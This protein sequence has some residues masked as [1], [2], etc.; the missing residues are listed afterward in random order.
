MVF[1]LAMVQR[2]KSAS[3]FRYGMVLLF[4]SLVSGVWAYTPRFRHFGIKD[5]LS[6]SSVTAL[7]QDKEGKIW[8]GTHDGLNCFYGT[9]FKRFY[10]DR[11]SKEGLNQSAISDL[12]CSADGDLWIATYGGGLSRM[13]PV[14]QQYKPLPKAFESFNWKLSNC[15]KEDP[16]GRLWFGFYEGLAVYNPA[17]GSLQKFSSLPGQGKK[18][19]SVISIGFDRSGSAIITTPFDGLAVFAIS[20]ESNQ[21]AFRE[22][23][24]QAQFSLQQKGIA[25]FNKIFNYRDQLFICSQEGI[26]VATF[27]GEKL[28]LKKEQ[29]LPE[30]ETTA[31]ETDAEGNFWIGN[32]AEGLSYY[33]KSSKGFEEQP[34]KFNDQP[35][36]KVSVL[37]KDNRGGMWVGH[38]SGL[39]YSHQQLAKFKS[40]TLF[41]LGTRSKLAITW[42]VFSE[43]DHHFLVGTELGLLF[44]DAET[45]QIKEISFAKEV[46]NEIIYSFLKTKDG[47]LFAGGSKGLYQILG[48]PSDPRIQKVLPQVVGMISALAQ[49]PDGRILAGT[50][51][52]RGFYLFSPSAASF[53]NFRHSKNN[54]NSLCNN[55]INCFAPE[56]S[57]KIW[58]GTD[59]GL[60]LFDPEKFRFDNSLWER[61]PHP[62]KNSQLIYGVADMG[63]ELWIAT[64]GSGILIYTKATGTWKQLGL[65]E[66]LSNEAVYQIQPHGELM[67]ASTN[68]GLCQIHLKTKKIA[69]FSE[70]DGL[71]SDEFNHFASFKNPTS[72]RIYFGG[73][74]GFDEVS[75]FLESRN[76]NSP[77]VVFSS[78]RLLSDRPNADLPIGAALWK[79]KPGERN[80]EVEFAALNYLM[81][82]KNTYAYEIEPGSGQI[83]LGSKSKLSLVNLQP[84]RYKLKIY[85]RNNEGLWSR[86]PLV[87]E[88]EVM[89]Y[90]WETFWFR[91]IIIFL[92]LLGLVLILT[93][94]YK[95]RLKQQRLE[96]ERLQAIRTERTRISAEMHDDLGSG[97]TSIRMMSELLQLKGLNKQVPEV[98]KISRRA[99]QLVDNLNTI[100][101]A[102]NE[103][104]DH[105]DAT[106]AYI[107][108]YSL[109]YLEENG[110]N[111]RFESIL[112]EAA[113]RKEI[114]GEVRRN[115][116]L[117]V[118]EA[119]HNLVKHAQATEVI[120]V[121][122]AMGDRLKLTIKDNGKGADLN[123]KSLGNGLRNMKERA[124]VMGG[125]IR[126]SSEGGFSLELNIP[127]Y[128]KSG[129]A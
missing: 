114:K 103:R 106:I 52:E 1:A 4:L 57:G 30:S 45:Q 64:F 84:G 91:A 121:F 38:A 15:I 60:S 129:I 23:V 95:S 108:A 5:G 54:E 47:N 42:S 35:E 104:N 2:C 34:W 51:D 33:R 31:L 19:L 115:L 63:S 93:F 78:A 18:T 25:Y 116:Y 99:E 6:T 71:Q 67:W 92:L 102:L 13:D 75:T 22:H 21:I 68:R 36:G 101:W 37:L 46:G 113:T 32:Q 66:G 48:Y 89:P 49:L 12:V 27:Q 80:L 118:K 8:I 70:G 11:K 20:K 72:G 128:N 53:L 62:E 28:K 107:R 87:Q 40:F 3:I 122:E 96:L 17:D 61:R 125:Q 97:L 90:F 7:C 117:I 83:P 74:Y 109:N 10:Q 73:L 58:I 14:S 65:D 119:L 43:D 127:L 100:V 77:K 123:S 79:L 112:D 9:F 44:F 88:L 59:Q 94:Y 120:M 50:Y 16:S 105:L 126:Y 26:W 86:E 29:N 81:P 82:E 41:P 124:E 98:D 39:S 85:G 111:I 24:P 110:I 55:S 76:V 69:V 56:P